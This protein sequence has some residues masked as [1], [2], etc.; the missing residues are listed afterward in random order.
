MN[1]TTTADAWL[2]LPMEAVSRLGELYRKHVGNSRMD[3]D[4]LHAAVLKE[5]RLAESGVISCTAGLVTELRSECA[6][7]GRWVNETKRLAK[8]T[9]ET[10]RI[11]R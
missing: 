11:S 1:A 5:K 2:L 6:E 3:L 8:Q 10:A 7:V 9:A 4:V